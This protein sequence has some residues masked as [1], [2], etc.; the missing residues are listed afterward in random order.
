M[1]EQEEWEE[2]TDAS[3]DEAFTNY[4]REY[5][6]NKMEFAKVTPYVSNILLPNITL[7]RYRE[8]QISYQLAKQFN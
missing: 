6:Q 3:E 8:D 4:K 2:D 1:E 7:N 5:Y